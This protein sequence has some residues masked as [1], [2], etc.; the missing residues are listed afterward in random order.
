M[1]VVFFIPPHA[2]KLSI[3]AALKI[4]APK[5]RSSLFLFPNYRT[6]TSDYSGHDKR[7]AANYSGTYVESTE[8]KQLD[9][10]IRVF[11]TKEK[12]L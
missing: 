9:L 6:E 3:E 11:Y 2:N 7:I 10:G 5:A 1:G 4:S 8:K 12:C